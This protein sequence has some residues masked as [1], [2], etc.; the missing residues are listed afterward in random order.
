MPMMFFHF[1][2]II[3]DIS[4]SKRSKMYKPY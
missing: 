1:L 3:F 2:K 4:T